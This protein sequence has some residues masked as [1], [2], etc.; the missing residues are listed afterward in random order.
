MDYV[1]STASVLKTDIACMERDFIVCKYDK[2]PIK[3]RF[4]PVLQRTTMEDNKRNFSQ[5][6]PNNRLPTGG[7]G[8]QET[9]VI[10]Q[11]FVGVRS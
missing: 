11:S 7:Q 3:H 4:V 8:W 5:F 9:K 2:K 6:L 1:N 10:Q